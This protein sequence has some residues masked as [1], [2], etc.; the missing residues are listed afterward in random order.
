MSHI[1]TTMKKVIRR[2]LYLLGFEIRRI[3]ITKSGFVPLRITMEES[4]QHIL[5]LNYYPEIII[6]VGAADGTPPLLNIFPDSRFLWI[7]PLVEFEKALKK[8]AEIYKGQYIIAAAGEFN[9]TATINIT[10][11][12]YGSSLYTKSGKDL[13][14]RKIRVIRL[15]DLIDEY[16]LKGDTLLKVDVQ[17]YELKVLE[18]AQRLLQNCEIVILEVSFFRFQKEFPDFY[19]VIDYMK[20]RNFV[21]YD[22]FDWL[23]RPLDGTLAQAN[24]LFVKEN[25]CFRQTHKWS[26]DFVQKKEANGYD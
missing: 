11:D 25:G 22:I 16:D 4:L 21:V 13:P 7:E 6:D 26:S 1:T 8:L 15:D 20:K 10:P 5:R 9:R 3:S 23:N 2:I 18:G 17:G 19:D 12:L 24:I 14:L